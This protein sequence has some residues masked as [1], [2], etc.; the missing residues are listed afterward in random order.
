MAKS[1]PEQQHNVEI[2]KNLVSW[3]N[4]NSLQK[5]YGKFYELIK[6][7]INLD[8]KGKIVELGSGVGNLKSKIPEAIC[9][10]LFNNPWI[11][12][13]ENAYNLSF[14]NEEV[15]N[16]ILFDV[17]HHLQYPG[18]AFNEFYRVLNP[19]GRVVIFEPDISFLGFIVYGLLHHEPIK[20][21]SKITWK[22]PLTID[23]S[24]LNYYAA[25][26]NASRVFRSK[27]YLQH[28]KQWKIVDKKRVASIS[29]IMT[30]GYSKPQMLPEKCFP[31]LN[32]L[33]KYLSFL[34]NLFSTRFL[35]VLEKC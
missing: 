26:G 12:Q 20:L 22:A 13:I 23:P 33:D 25:Q 3:N 31:V 21:F 16:I 15:S 11:D 6:Q 7:Q 8:V 29:Y 24:I 35:I 9:T 1:I 34:P 27:K 4:K 17:F 28:F 5:V 32:R 10:D 14:D 2:Q 18:E 30:G 19:K